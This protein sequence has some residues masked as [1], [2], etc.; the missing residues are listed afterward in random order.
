[1]TAKDD[2]EHEIVNPPLSEGR[3]TTRPLE[4]FGA[5]GIDARRVIDGG[6]S[7]RQWVDAATATPRDLDALA[8]PDEQAWLTERQAHLRY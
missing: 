5:P 2:R 6:L 7:L 4:P 3:A 8:L 1:V